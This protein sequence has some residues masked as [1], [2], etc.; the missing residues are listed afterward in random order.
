MIDRVNHETLYRP[1]QSIFRMYGVTALDLDLT[2]RHAVAEHRFGMMAQR[3]AYP[4]DAGVVGPEEADVL[5]GIE[6]LEPLCG[7][8]EPDHAVLDADDE[9]N[10]HQ[11]REVFLVPGLDDEMGDRLG[12]RI[13]DHP[14]QLPALPVGGLDVATDRESFQVAA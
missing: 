9:V 12:S 13:D 8:V 3:H 7:A 10:R 1:D 5:G 6:L 4:A 14:G 2:G 11:S